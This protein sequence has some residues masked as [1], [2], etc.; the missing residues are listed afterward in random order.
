VAPAEQAS[1]YEFFCP[2]LRQAASDAIAAS[3]AKGGCCAVAP[4]EQASPYEFFCPDIRQAACDALAASMA[5]G[6]CC[7]V[8]PAEQASLY[9]FFR[10]DLR[11]AARDALP[12]GPPAI[13]ASGRDATD[14]QPEATISAR[15]RC[16]APFFGADRS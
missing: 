16:E 8:A 1:L 14:G 3:T 15:N 2:D 10:P 11:Q 12:N 7:A 4:A 5:K 6:G 9:E 13:L